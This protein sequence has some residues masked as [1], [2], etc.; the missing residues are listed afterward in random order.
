MKLSFYSIFPFLTSLFL[1]FLSFFVYARQ[2][3]SPVNR[4]FSRYIFFTF[5]WLFFYAI[6][7][8]TLTEQQAFFWLKIGYI[9]V[10]LMPPTF[11]HFTL[12]LLNLKTKSHQRILAFLYAVSLLFIFTLF[13]TDFL[14]SGLYKYFWGYYPKGGSLHP[15]YLAIVIFTVSF[16]DLLLFISWLKI[17]RESSLF[18]F[19]LQ[20]IFLAFIIFTF[21]IADFIP[22]YGIELYPSGWIF[23]ILFTSIIAY[24][25]LR[26][27]L[28][29]IYVVI[30]R[31]AA[32]SLS[33][34]LLTAFFAILVI[35]ATNLLSS[36]ANVSSL[37]IS[38][39]AALV[40]AI[41]FNPLRNRIQ[42]LI[43][44]LFYKKTYDYYETIGKVTR[45]L[46]SMFELDRIYGFVGE[47]ICST[48]GLNSIYVLAA[49][50]TGESYEAVYQ[51]SGRENIKKEKPGYATTPKFEG[52]K[53]VLGDHSELI[54][55]LE[56]SK[57]IVIKDEL[58]SIDKEMDND[59]I[60]SVMKDFKLF[61]GE[62]AV[63]V[64]VDRKFV[65]VLVLGG[66]LSGDMYTTEDINLLN[67]IAN[68]TAISIRNA[69]LYKDKVDSERMASIGMMSATFAHE[70]RNPLTSL[71]TFAQL[72]P[73]KYN[74]EEFRNYFSKIVEGEIDRIDGLIRDLLDFSTEKK[75][76]RSNNFNLVSLIDETVEYVKGKLDFEKKKISI[77][78]NYGN[79]VI[80]MSGDATNLKQAFI[81]IIMNGCQAMN[82]EGTLKV[83]IYPNREFM[84]VAITDTGEGIHPDDISKIFDPF[85]TTKEMGIGL[86]LAIS[87]RIVE[88]HKGSIH[89][90]S[91]LSKGTT[92]TI[93]LPVQI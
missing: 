15:A 89:V 43:D 16:C 48:L 56:R 69:G 45:E 82:G 74:D 3:S 47:V 54:K 33:A 17:R 68:Q 79:N 81:N 62:A 67:T 87:K 65:L 25:I 21:A 13:E 91:Q 39:F 1:L 70:V 4:A 11:Y 7:Y 14:V 66:K 46:E 53:A 71:K 9:G 59:I 35:T 77:E 24:A 8:S 12:A 36:I 73:E 32:Y 37:K 60:D 42:L 51:I 18:K 92:F 6:S 58:S 31:T 63:P 57:S 78:K 83:H 38:I 72:M 90:K 49:G 10:I 61:D 26:Y 28:L 64:S 2:S 22:N 34:G 76:S 44:K 75:S 40:I 50:T 52:K 41:L 19:R 27:R 23:V 84:E 20:Y 5:I 88:D 86:G 55:L 29:D 85:I 80:E 93:S 30:K